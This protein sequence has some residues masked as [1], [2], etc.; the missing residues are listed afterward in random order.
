M[1]IKARQRTRKS[2]SHTRSTQPTLL[3]TKNSKELIMTHV[4]A[5]KSVAAIFE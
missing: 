4:K 3:D 5:G 2:H 1:Q